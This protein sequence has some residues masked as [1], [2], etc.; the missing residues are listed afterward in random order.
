MVFAKTHFPFFYHSQR[1]FTILD[2]INVLIEGNLTRQ[3]GYQESFSACVKN[4]QEL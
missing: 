2:H 3:S 4:H 1:H